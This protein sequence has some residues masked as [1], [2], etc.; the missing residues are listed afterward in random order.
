[1]NEPL[2]DCLQ[3][4]KQAV[5]KRKAVILRSEA[6]KNLLFQ[7]VD[8]TQQQILRCAQDDKE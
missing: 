2:P 5:E 4:L 7:A 1:M 6:T 3:R 8:S